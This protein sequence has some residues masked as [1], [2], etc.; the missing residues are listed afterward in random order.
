MIR[1][2]ET[3]TIQK[4]KDKQRKHNPY[5]AEPIHIFSLLHATQISFFAFSKLIVVG[6]SVDIGLTQKTTNIFDYSNYITTK[7]IRYMK[8]MV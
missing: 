1:C 8:Q 6:V 2:I 3:T 5:L 7:I 4:I